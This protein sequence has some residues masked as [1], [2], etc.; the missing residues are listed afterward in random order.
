SSVLAED[1]ANTGANPVDSSVVEG[2]SLTYTVALSAAGIAASEYS[3]AIG[4]TAVAADYAS[5]SFSDGVAWKNGDAQ[6]G[7]IVVPAG[8]GSF[9]ITVATT[10]DAAIESAESLT[11]TVGGVAASGTITD[12]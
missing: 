7:I 2:G 8:I 9:R 5:I 4:G 11:L 1:A 10:D 3:L 6:T 12:N